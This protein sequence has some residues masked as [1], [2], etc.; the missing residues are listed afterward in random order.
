MRPKVRITDVANTS[1]H[2]DDPGDSMENGSNGST[3]LKQI[4]NLRG[5]RGR[6]NIDPVFIRTII[7]VIGDTFYEFIIVDGLVKA[8]AD[9]NNR[10]QNDN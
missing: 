7:L 8:I 5:N 6:V 2:V 3:T 9:I 1:F 4:A 10:K